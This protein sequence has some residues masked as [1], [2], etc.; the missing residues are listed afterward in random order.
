MTNKEDIERELDEVKRRFRSLM[1]NCVDA[2]IIINEDGT[3]CP[4]SY[5]LEHSRA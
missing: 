3:I 5:K 1:D 4:S 2:M